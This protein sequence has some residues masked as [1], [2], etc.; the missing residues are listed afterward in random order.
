MTGRTISICLA[1]VLYAASAAEPY[2][3]GPPKAR[4]AVTNR[5]FTGIP[6]LCVT[7]KGRLWA[8]WYAGPTPGE[9]R[10]NYIVLATSTDS[11]ETWKE[12]AVNDPDENGPNRCY[13]A[14]LWVTPDRRLQWNWSER[15]PSFKFSEHGSEGDYVVVMYGDDPESETMNWTPR[16]KIADGVAMGKS[17]R[18]STGEWV[19]PV[20]RWFCE[21]SSRMF[22]STDDGATWTMRGG[23][24]YPT[25]PRV[26]DEHQF[27]ENA[28]GTI[29]CFSRTLLG[30]GWSE[31]KDRGKTWAPGILTWIPQ[32][33][34]RFLVRRLK[35][36]RMLL[37]KHGPMKMN[38]AWTP[39]GREQLMAF[40]SED[41]GKTWKGGLMLDAR[42]NVSYPD[43]DQAADGTIYVIHDRER[44]AAREI[45]LSRFT[46]EDVLAGKPVSAVA[47]L[48]MLVS[49]GTSAA[50]PVDPWAPKNLVPAFKVAELAT[51]NVPGA[52]AEPALAGRPIFADRKYA[53]ATLPTN[54]KGVWYLPVGMDGVKRLEVTS[55]G[56]LLFL[57]PSPESNRDNCA[58]EFT[59]IGFV[60]ASTSGFQLF[61]P[62]NVSSVVEIWRR[63]CR[64]GDIITFGK[65]AVPLVANPTKQ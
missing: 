21:P 14:N 10:N 2:Y 49:K 19:M 24:T 61:E 13:D 3:F 54:L 6:S 15:L 31:S 50:L 41:D 53:F 59:R 12:V 56:E 55:D 23:V 17:I 64:K 52:T 8:T 28:D 1:A 39:R 57:T 47:K 40:L 7:P 9:D 30:I 18:L 20:C 25:N 29:Q 62:A 65:W 48:K 22:V 42:K 45:L 43:G 27:V 5:Q 4:Q 26:F 34:A 33:N 51:A 37:V 35:S 63:P 60:R 58:A 46:E 32:P 44:T 11:G 36:G 16:R 38:Y